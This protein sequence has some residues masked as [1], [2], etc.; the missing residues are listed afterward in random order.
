MND[1]SVFMDIENYKKDKSTEQVLKID[2]EGKQEWEEI[3]R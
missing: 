2:K 3:V 1:P